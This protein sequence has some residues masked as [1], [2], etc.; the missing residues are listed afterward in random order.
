MGTETCD[1]I[2]KGL[3][4][5]YIYETNIY[6]IYIQQQNQ[7]FPF[8]GRNK[9]FGFRKWPAEKINLT[10]NNLGVL[11]MGYFPSNAWL[12]YFFHLEFKK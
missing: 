3:L 10:D 9:H 8:W 12:C 11:S 7:E 6:Y 2:Y 5:V 4:L 1:Y